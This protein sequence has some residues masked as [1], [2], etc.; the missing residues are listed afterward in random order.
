MAGLVIGGL[1]F[2]FH[3]GGWVSV[4]PVLVPVASAVAGWS[5]EPSPCVSSH[6]SSISTPHSL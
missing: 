6:L 1:V 4:V 2:Q 5:L 3:Y